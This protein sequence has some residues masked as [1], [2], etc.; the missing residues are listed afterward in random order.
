SSPILARSSDSLRVAL[1]GL[2]GVIT[3]SPEQME[4][5]VRRFKQ[6]P[7]RPTVILADASFDVVSVLEEHRVDFPC[8][9]IHAP[10]GGYCPDRE[11]VASFVAYT[12]EITESELNQRQNRGYKSG[13]EIGK[14]GLERQYE[15]QLRGKE[16]T[17]FVEGDARGGVVGEAGRGGAIA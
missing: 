17:H 16:G 3:L 8:L 7:N 15:D 1:T 5:A 2:A 6:A 10:P 14:A 4:A 13:Q 9:L 12:G 11:V